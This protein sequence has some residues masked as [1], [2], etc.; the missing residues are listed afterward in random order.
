MARSAFFANI[1][2][3]PLL[4][5][6]RTA[7]VTG[8]AAVLGSLM[9]VWTGMRMIL[10]IDSLR[11]WFIP[12][13]LLELCVSAL[14]PLFYFALY[15][16]EVLPEFPK[17]L[18]ILSLLVAIIFSGITV[19]ELPRWFGSFGSYWATIRML[20][21]R[22]GAATLLDVVR[23]PGTYRQ[24]ASLMAVLWNFAYVGLLVAF[25][26]QDPKESSRGI[27]ISSFLSLMTKIAFIA[28]ALVVAG[29]LIRLL[30]MPYIYVQ[31]RD[32]A[33][34]NG[35]TPPRLATLILD[36]VR[37]LLLQSCLFSAPYV[38]YRSC[39]RRARPVEP[40]ILSPG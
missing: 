33:I 40:V 1:G 18:R 7:L 14:M 38:V 6:R 19:A 17:R 39:L 13:L 10:G 37:T 35:V 4:D 5:I 15:H 36:A 29:C 2:I 3:M 22:P 21:W 31:L 20:D 32:L 9:P 12:F 23:E 8:V 27:P 24:L 34:Q 26:R 11:S 28:G 25:F 16:N 30:F